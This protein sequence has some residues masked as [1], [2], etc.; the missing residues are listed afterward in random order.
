MLIREQSP[1]DQ[2]VVLQICHVDVSIVIDA[3]VL[4]VDL[5]AKVHLGLRPTMD[6][7]ESLLFPPSFPQ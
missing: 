7:Y 6:A 2:I 1:Q 4:E 5:C 3:L